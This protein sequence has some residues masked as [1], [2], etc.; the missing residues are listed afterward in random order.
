M[1][2]HLISLN[3]IN[4][5]T[6]QK[7]LKQYMDILRNKKREVLVLKLVKGFMNFS[8]PF[9]HYKVFASVLKLIL[10]LSHSQ[11]CIKRG[12][13]IN[14]TVLIWNPTLLLLVKQSLNIC[15]RI[16]WSCIIYSFLSSKLIQSVKAARSWY[17]EFLKEQEENEIE[18][19]KATQLEVI[20]LQNFRNML[21]TRSI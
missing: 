16:I 11:A 19:E 20:Q 10:T 1:V 17:S 2:H 18:K 4:T 9:Y 3:I 13:S 5:T 14:N 12:F 8:F 6:A 21:E 7:T 15:R